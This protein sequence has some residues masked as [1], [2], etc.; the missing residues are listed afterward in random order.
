SG[1]ADVRQFSAGPH[2]GPSAIEQNLKADRVVKPSESSLKVTTMEE[3]AADR[4]ETTTDSEPEE[5]TNQIVERFLK[6]VAKLTA[7]MQPLQAWTSTF[8]VSKKP[9]QVRKMISICQEKLI[10]I[11]DQEAKVNRLQLELEHMHL[12]SD[13][14]PTHLKQANDAFEKFAKVRNF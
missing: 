11:K 14:T 3:L 13:L 7:E 6:H 2:L 10:E 1:K 12:S 5:P 9:D 8:A 4:M